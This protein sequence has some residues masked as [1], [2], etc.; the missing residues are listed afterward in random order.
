[1]AEFTAPWSVSGKVSEDF[2]RPFMTP[3]ERVVAFHYIVEGALNVTLSDGA[4]WRLRAGEVVLLPH[5]DLHVFSSSEG[6]APVAVSEIVRAIEG[7][8]PA[9]IVY[10]GGGEQTRMVCGFL[11][12]NVQLHP[13]LANLPPVIV[14]DLTALPSGGWMAQTFDYAARMRAE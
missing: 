8:G 2:C 3:P 14:L 11:G 1:D 5:N 10:G 7:H 13:L 6:I 4:T 9:R 12:G